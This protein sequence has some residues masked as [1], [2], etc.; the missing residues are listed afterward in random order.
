MKNTKQSTTIKSDYKWLVV[1]VLFF[2]PTPGVAR[3]VE[4]RATVTSPLQEKKQYTGT[5]VDDTGE[6]LIGV[7]VLVKG[8][9]QGAIT[10][11]DGRFELPATQQT[12]TLVCSFIGYATVETTV[13]TGEHVR[14]VL[15]EDDLTLDEVV[16]TGYGTFKK[17]AYAG[18]ASTVKVENMEDI[19]ATS[20]AQLLQGS[21]PGVQISSS[22]GAVGGSNSIM[23]RGVGSFN[24]STNPLY[25][26]DGV[27]VLSSI[28]TNIDGGTDI[29][30]TLNNSDIENITV[31]KDAAAASLYGSRA[32]NGVI[33]ITTKSG[34]EGKAAFSLKGDWG[35]SDYATRYR[36]VMDGP[37]RRATIWEGLY[38]QAIYLNGKTPQEATAYADGD[39]D[40]YAPVPWSG[41]ED[42]EAALFRRHAPYQ[43]YDFSA[44]GGDKKL[45]YYM[46]AAYTN[47][48]GI[49][50]QQDFSRIT[51]RLN[52][53]Y[54]MTPRLQLGANILYSLLKQSGSAEGSTYTSPV[55]AT[56][57]K[58]SAS[59]PI[60]NE[61]GTYNIHF[62]ANDNR[63]P[64]SQLDLNHKRQQANRTFNTVF[65]NYKFI[66]GLVFNT[67]FSLD[68]MN[69]KYSG[70]SDPRSTD[71]ARDN[72]VLNA[73]S[74][75]YQTIVWKNNLTYNA[76]FNDFH[77][78]DLLGGYEVEQYKRT[79]IAGTVKDFATVDKPQLSNG[80]NVTALS[81]NE[82]TRRL[83]SYIG[84]LNYD[85]RNRYYFGGSLRL[86]GT[87]R[88]H[89]SSRWG[90]FWSVSAA[91]RPTAES[92]MEPVSDVLTDLKIRAS[93]GTNGTQ[94][95]EDFGYMS[96][97]G[98]KYAYN[99]KPGMLE[100]QIGN[101][102]LSWE[103]NHNLNIGVDFNLFGRVSTTVEFYNRNTADLLLDM[104]LSRTTG[105]S[106]MLTNI[107]KVNNKGIE[108][109]INAGIFKTAD[110]LWNSALNFGHNK[111]KI[112]DLGG[113]QEIVGTYTIRKVGLPYYMFYVKEF[114][115]INPESGYARYYV[116]GENGI[117]KDGNRLIT[118]NPN[119][120]NY[121]VHKGAD[122]TLSGGWTNT[123]KYKWFDLNFMLTF[124]LGGYSY[125]NAAQRLEHGGVESEHAIS[126]IYSNRWKN[127]GDRT[128]MEL[129]M[130]GN[131][132][133]MHKVVNSRR[134]HSTNH[135]RLKNLTFGV[136]VPGKWVQKIRLENVRAY[137]SAVNLLTFAKY[138]MYDPE[139]PKNGVVYFEAPKMKTLTFGL[140]IKF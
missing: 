86:D 75:Q 140:D 43:N 90:T 76:T 108:V 85:Y 69:A 25:V 91:W 72:G 124:S 106:S 8:T 27:P 105:F 115:G 93:F 68:Q 92:F 109:S 54:D 14:I 24:A 104:P 52:V 103:K 81:G 49:I 10:D 121:I 2:F 87:S 56:R 73:N 89:R 33:L 3:S 127:P 17:S 36:E 82:R 136:S 11:I 65:A 32:A 128:N 66:P 63:N 122:P 96:L 39:I 132:N 74:Y 34:K 114:A 137:F 45:S 35:F 113:Q 67:T 138:D 59:D 64:K 97:V 133:A 7:N 12:V 71:G 38:N 134:I 62:L 13:R 15:K 55:Y 139:T 101:E 111:N 44:S 78:L 131:P 118:E 79:N 46:S 4:S 22:S 110:F 77:H 70:W 125:D 88:L 6:P 58:V 1:C 19:P 40:K 16:V 42:W 94:P 51:G 21:A 135:L 102:R 57:H 107:G 20:F 37:E 126:A 23:I 99:G 95:S 9:T 123:F 53:K 116:N 80:A 41:W 29:M 31:I 28:S 98:F 129:F 48:K 100:Y 60:Y 30:S 18:S 83:L 117:D 112:V 50:R 47:Q 84:R 130:M 119:E 61:D 26:I 5:I 120:A